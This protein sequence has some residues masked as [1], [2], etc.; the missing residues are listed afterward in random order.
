MV[1][2]YVLSQQDYYRVNDEVSTDEQ[3]VMTL[4]RIKR[5]DTLALCSFLGFSL[6]R[7]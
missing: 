2:N 4:R 1:T 3:Y 5:H 7:R 6:S